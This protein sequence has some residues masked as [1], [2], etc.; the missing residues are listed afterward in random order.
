MASEGRVRHAIAV[1]SESPGA[2]FSAFLATEGSEMQRAKRLVVRQVGL[3]EPSLRVVKQGRI[4]LSE[5]PILHCTILH[6]VPQYCTRR[7]S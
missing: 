5:S 1:R 7:N 3:A 4:L 2:A 6:N